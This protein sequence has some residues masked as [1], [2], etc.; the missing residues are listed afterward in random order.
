MTRAPRLETLEERVGHTFEDPGLLE[1]ALVHRSYTS[2]HP[3]VTDNERMEFLG[4][5]VLQLAVTDYLFATHPGLDEGE[6]AKV[7]AA[8]VNRAT[9]A[10]VARTLE[11]GAHLRIG[12]GEAQSGGKDKDS[13][14]AD[15]MEAVLAAV[16]LDSGYPT[17]RQVILRLWKDL[18]DQ[19]ASAPGRRDYKTRLQEVLAAVGSQPRYEVVGA[20]PDHARSFE[21]VVLV[22]G[23]EQGRGSGRSK[24]AAQQEAARAALEQRPGSDG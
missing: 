19:K 2:E 16:Y 18:V 3:S 9:L 24:K 17:A 21:A 15:G 6:M 5:A 20:G 23:V 10:E 12:L 4:D 22:D 1:A 13:I 8:C 14:L 7:R 11:L